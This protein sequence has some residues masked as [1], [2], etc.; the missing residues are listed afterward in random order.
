VHLDRTFEQNRVQFARNKTGAVVEL[1]CRKSPAAVRLPVSDPVPAVA[2]LEREKGLN[3]TASL[4]ASWPE[5]ETP[6]ALA[7]IVV[8]LLGAY[9]APRIEGAESADGD[10]VAFT[11]EDARTSL[12][13][14]LPYES[15]PLV[16]RVENRPGPEAG[17]ARVRA[18]EAF[19]LAKRKA[20][21][22]A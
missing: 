5:E 17:D 13:L 14:R 16:F 8:P 22:D 9:G 6:T 3:L 4:T 7:K 21:L 18:A 19:D 1:D 10:G 12:S 15:N 11:W 2:V 20:R